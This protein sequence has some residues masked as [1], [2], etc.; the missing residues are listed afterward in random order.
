MVVFDKKTAVKGS[1][2]YVK[3]VDCTSATLLG[4]LAKNENI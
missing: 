2:V 3:I 1:Y 4:E